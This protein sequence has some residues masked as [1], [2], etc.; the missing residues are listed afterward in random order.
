MQALR[1]A[2]QIIIGSAFALMAIGIVGMCVWAFWQFLLVFFGLILGTVVLGGIVWMG[3]GFIAYAIQ[4]V[5]RVTKER[6][7]R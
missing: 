5:T 2:T 1:I 6:R 7:S 3:F 4:E